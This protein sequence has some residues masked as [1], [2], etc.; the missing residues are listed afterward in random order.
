MRHRVAVLPV[1]KI[2]PSLYAS[3]PVGAETGYS[4]LPNVEALRAYV[5]DH[6]WIHLTLGVWSFVVGSAP[7]LVRATG[8]LIVRYVQHDR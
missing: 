6:R 7:M 1:R 3:E 2:R 4:H 8:E 5:D